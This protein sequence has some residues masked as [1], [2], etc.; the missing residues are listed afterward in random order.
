M[1]TRA[2]DHK[3]KDHRTPEILEADLAPLALEMAYWGVKN[4]ETLTWVTPPP[5]GT[6]AQAYEL[7][8]QL[9]IIENRKITEHGKKIQTLPCHPRIAHKLLLAKDE[10]LLPLATDLAAILEERDP[11]SG[12]DN[13]IDI[14]I[15]VNALRKFRAEKIGGKQFIQIEKVAA[16]YRNLFHID[17]D[18]DL[19]NPFETGLLLVFAYPERIASAR[20]G[21]NAQFQLSNGRLAMVHHSP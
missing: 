16:S 12:K 21:N 20:P 14:N 4:A 3:R 8:D 15:R 7:L 17:C 5:S 18:N 11:L 1:W 19:V 10:G 9:G 13:G 6:L 2:S